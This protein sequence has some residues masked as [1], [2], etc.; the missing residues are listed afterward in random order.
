MALTVSQT[1]PHRVSSIPMC[2][3]GCMLR[4]VVVIQL[5][6]PITMACQQI[7]VETARLTA[8]Q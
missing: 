2:G 1:V 4:F 5:H 8:S 3:T 7:S 6:E